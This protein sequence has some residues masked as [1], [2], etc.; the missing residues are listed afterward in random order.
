MSNTGAAGAALPSPDTGPAGFSMAAGGAGLPAR[1]QPPRSPRT[2]RWPGVDGIVDMVGQ[3]MATSFETAPRLLPRPRDPVVAAHGPRRRQQ[4][5]RVPAS[6]PPTRRTPSQEAAAL[7]SRAP[8]ARSR[9]TASRRPTPA[10]T[11]P[12]RGVA[13]TRLH[14]RR[15][16]RLL[17]ADRG[18][19][20]RRSTPP[21]SPRRK[22]SSS[23][24]TPA[25]SRSRPATSSRSPAWCA[26]RTARPRS[27][28]TAPTSTCS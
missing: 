9:A 17:H 8:S 22:A 5:R 21:R 18:Q 23:T 24:S 12:C 4:Q 16:V 2:A 3:T 19:R 27:A 28:P 15:A 20:R 10:S 7:R 14:E 6:L 11:S 26:R 13:S 25:P 1:K